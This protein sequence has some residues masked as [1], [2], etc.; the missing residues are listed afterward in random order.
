MLSP[1]GSQ[2]TCIP[3]GVPTFLSA[4]FT[5]HRMDSPARWAATMAQIR[6]CSAAVSR[7]VAPRRRALSC[8]SCRTRWWSCSRVSIA[9]RIHAYL[10][11]VQQTG[12]DNVRYFS[13]DTGKPCALSSAQSSPV[14]RLPPLAVV[15][16]HRGYRRRVGHADDQARPRSSGPENPRAT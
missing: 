11:S 5:A 16:T 6:S 9:L 1:K 14:H 3:C 4:A 7:V 10:L 12:Q 8:C 13:I 15:S 2:G